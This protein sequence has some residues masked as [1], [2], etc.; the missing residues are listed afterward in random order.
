M[1]KLID[2]CDF[3]IIPFDYFSVSGSATPWSMGFLNTYQ[4]QGADKAGAIFAY[5]PGTIANVSGATMTYQEVTNST[6]LV[7][8]N[9]DGTDFLSGLAYPNDLWYL[10]DWSNSPDILSFATGT[11]KVSGNTAEK[12]DLRPIIT[13][14]EPLPD[15]PRFLVDY[16]IGD[17][18]RVQIRRGSLVYSGSPRVMGV[19]VDI[20]QEGYERASVTFA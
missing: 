2:G 18:V 17:T 8:T 14:T 3:E 19:T 5:G 7:A 1:T 20:N 6:F 12:K 13:I 15:A 16:F 9:Q 11:S 10:D 4:K